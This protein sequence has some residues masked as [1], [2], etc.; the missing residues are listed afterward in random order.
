MFES[1]FIQLEKLLFEGNQGPRPAQIK[2]KPP[3][4]RNGIFYNTMDTILNGLEKEEDKN[5]NNNSDEVKP[6]V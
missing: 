2:T 6:G 5:N 1:P 3:S 4:Q